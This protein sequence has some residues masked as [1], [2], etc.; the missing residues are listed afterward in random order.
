MVGKFGSGGTAEVESNS[1]VRGRRDRSAGK[2]GL[3]TD[4]SHRAN[5]F[6]LTDPSQEWLGT[7]SRDELNRIAGACDAGRTAKKPITAER[8]SRWLRESH[9]RIGT[10]RTCLASVEHA[11]TTGRQ[12]KGSAAG[13]RIPGRLRT[14]DWSSRTTRRRASRRL[15][16]G[17]CRSMMSGSLPRMCRLTDERRRSSIV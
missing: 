5:E 2:D 6:Q 17:G 8:E 11:A 12:R 9:F 16:T 15:E 7:H 13:A 14:A 10:E 1:H 3:V 4:R